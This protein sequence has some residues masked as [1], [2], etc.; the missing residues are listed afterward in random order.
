MM[1]KKER[2]KKKKLSLLSHVEEM[3]FNKG[4]DS[5]LPIPCLNFSQCQQSTFVLNF[6][7]CLK[8]SPG[9]ASH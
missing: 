7:H 4:I 1:E 5:S 3:G 6:F 9:L 2:K 8:F